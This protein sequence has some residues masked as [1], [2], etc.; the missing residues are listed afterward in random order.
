ME[1]AWETTTSPRT[2]GDEWDHHWEDFAAANERNPAQEYRRRL[3]LELLQRSGAIPDRLLDIGS[4]SGELLLAASACWP[5]AQLFGLELS[6]S[7]VAQAQ[8]KLPSARFRQVDLLS[9]A[10][11]DPEEASWATHAICSEVLEHVDDPVR[12]L[13]N[14]RKWM[15]AGCLLVV[16]V[17][18]GPMSAFDRYIGHR[19]HFRPRDLHALLADSGLETLEVAAA[20]FPFFNLYRALV[21]SRGERLITEAKTSSDGTPS[22]L[23][24]T[25][26]FVFGALFRLNLRNSRYGWQTVAVAREPSGS[27]GEDRP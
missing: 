2:A 18:G 26:M 6:E 16:T 11:P 4:G 23:L 12:L 7:A 21:I 9:G 19:R 17:P 13:R 14:A 27:L 3:V 25:G 20:G 8:A 24:R 22:R 15:R 1:S 5:R 10:A